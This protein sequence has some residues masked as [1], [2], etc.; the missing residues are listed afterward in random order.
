MIEIPEDSVLEQIAQVASE[1]EQT[2]T[3]NHVAAVLAAY[4]NVMGGDPIGTVRRD[5]ETGALALR[6]KADGLHMWR[7]SVPD[8]TQYNDLQPTLPWPLLPIGP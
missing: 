6:V 5:P 2:L 4:S 8:G 1:P 7:V 3:R